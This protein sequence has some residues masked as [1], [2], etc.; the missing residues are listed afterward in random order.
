MTSHAQVE[1]LLSSLQQEMQAQGQWLYELMSEKAMMSQQPF[2]VDTMTFSQ[3]L[4]FIFIPRMQGLV[5][6]KL[7]LPRLTRGQGIEP[8][9]SE[10]FKQFKNCQQIMHVIAEFDELLAS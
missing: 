10:Y 4:Q 1:D 8:M 2:C 6:G 5:D 7:E 9:A 3:W